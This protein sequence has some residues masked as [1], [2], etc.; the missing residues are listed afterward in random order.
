MAVFD[1]FRHINATNR[2]FVCVWDGFEWFLA[3]FWPFYYKMVFWGDFYYRNGGFHTQKHSKTPK[4]TSK[5][6]KIASKTPKITP[7]TPQNPP[8]SQKKTLDSV[9]GA[10]KAVVWIILIVVI[11][12][13]E[14]WLKN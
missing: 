6:L 4:N 5:T 8:K 2:R 13:A 9:G 7:K 14:K 1:A 11:V 3:V 10:E 12:S